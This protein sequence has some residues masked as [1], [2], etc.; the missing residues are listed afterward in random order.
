MTDFRALCAELLGALENEGHAHWPGGPD[1]DP[2]IEQARAALT[3]EPVVEGPTDEEL[4]ATLNKATA[5]FPPRH[6][7]AEALNAVEYALELELRKARAA[8]SRYGHQPAPPDE[9][10]VA[11]LARLLRLDAHLERG[12]GMPQAAARFDRAADLLEQ[13]HPTPVPVDELLAAYRSGAADAA[14]PTPVPVSERL[15]GPGDCDGEGR[16]WWGFEETDDYEAS[17]TLRK[18]IG[19]PFDDTHW[20]PFNALPLPAGEVQP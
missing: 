12:D 10:E 18:M 2:L 17:W 14:H 19:L 7:E 20:L 11:E 3:A 16:C 5:E 6:P 15:P 8:I 1:G 13:R 4:L 9:G